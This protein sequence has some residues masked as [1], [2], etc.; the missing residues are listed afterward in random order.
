MTDG[1]CPLLQAASFSFHNNAK[2]WSQP[3][4][5]LPERFLTKGHHDTSMPAFCAF[6]DGGR[7]C[8]GYRFARAD[9]KV[10]ALYL[11]RIIVAR[12]NACRPWLLT[13]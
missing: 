2:Y 13:V 9:A 10:A 1:R 4:E 11:V 7:S 6:G 8:V 5:F 3:A 12:A